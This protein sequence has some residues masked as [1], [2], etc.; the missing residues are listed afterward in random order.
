VRSSE[1]IPV[2]VFNHLP[3]QTKL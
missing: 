2:S 1:S 3:S